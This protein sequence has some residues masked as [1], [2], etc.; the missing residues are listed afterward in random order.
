MLTSAVALDKV[1]DIQSVTTDPRI[2]KPAG[3]KLLVF[4]P[5]AEEKTANGVWL[6]EKERDLSSQST[7]IVYVVAMGAAAYTDHRRF[8]AGPLCQP[9][10]W[11]ITR[12]YSGARIK[13][14]G[15][16]GEDYEFRLIND[17]S[18]EATVEDPREIRRA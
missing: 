3:Y 14:K 13:I 10:E 5:K 17:D 4:V 7:N 12:P 8:P 9:G 11:V 16:D 18:V 2:P 6:P 15:D 1:P